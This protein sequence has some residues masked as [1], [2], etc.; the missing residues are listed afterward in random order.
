MPLAASVSTGPATIT[1]NWPNPGNASLLILRRTKGQGGASW[2]QILNV[3]NSNLSMLT[4]NGVAAGQIYEYVIQRNVGGL[5]AFGYAHVAINANPVNS[6]GKILIF[7]DSTTADAAGVELVRMKNDMRGDGWWPIP[8]KT[9]PAATPQSVKAQIVTA[10]NA[11]PLNVKAVLLIGNVPIP[12][13]GNTNWDGH[14]EHAGAWPCDA[15]YG[16]IN[17]NWTDVSINNTSPARDANDNVPGDGKFDQSVI[18]SVVELQVGRIDFRRLDPAAFGASDHV[19][20]LKRYLEKNHRWRTGQ[21]T[22]DNK[23]LV[24]DNFGYFGGEAFAANGF[25]N[26]YPLVGQLNL[27]EGDFFN[28]TDNQSFLMGYGCGGGNYNG[29]GGVGSSTNFMSDSVN[30]V[31]SNLFGSYFGD[32]DFES[33]PFMPSALA[34]RGG[35]LT[36]SWAGRPHHFYQAL[37][38][39]ETVGYVMWETMNA[40]FNNGFYGSYGESGAHVALLGDPTLRAHVVKPATNLTVAPGGCSSVVLNW[41]A[42]AD[43]VSGYHIY[44]ALSQD[45]PYTRLTVN[46]VAG[47]TFT[48]NTPLLDTLF[49]QVRAIKNVSSFG[50]GTYA[51]NAVGPIEFLV[52]TGQGGPTVTATGGA[53][54]CSAFTVTLS[55]DATPASITSWSWSGPNGFSSNVQNPTVSTAGVYTV[56]A[57][58]A[59][60]CAATATATVILD[61]TA[62]EIEATV[63]NSINCANNSAQ[64]TVSTTGLS[65]ISISGPNGF[66]VTGPTATATQTGTYTIT[67]ISDANGCFGS[68]TVDLAGD[69][70]QPEVSATNSGLINCINSTSGLLA[71]ANV[72]GA[73]FSWE[74]PCLDG[75]VATCGGTYTVTAVNTNNGCTG[76]A[77]TVVEENFEVPAGS[78]PNPPM[79]TCATPSVSLISNPI[80]AGTTVVWDGPCLIPGTPPM[81]ECA[82]TYSLVAT[83]PV[84]GCTSVASVNVTAN[85]TPPVV[86]LPPIPAITCATPCISFVVPDIPNIRLYYQG[87]LLPVGFVIEFCQPGVFTL[88]AISLLNGCSSEVLIVVE[89]DVDL[90]VANAGPDQTLTCASSSVQLNGD[91][92][93]SGANFTRTWSGPNGYVSS[94]LNPTVSIAGVYVLTV[95]NTDNGCTTT[96]AVTVIAD[97]D[98]PI[99]NPSV[100]GIINCANPIVVLQSGNNNPAA[101]YLWVGPGFASSLPT[102]TVSVP[103]VYTVQVVIGNCSASGSVEVEQAP[104]LDVSGTPTVI[105]CDGVASACISVSGGTPPYAILWS[106]G[107]TTPCAE[108]NTPAMIGVSVTDNGGCTFTVDPVLV[109]SIPILMFEG[110]TVSNTCN[111]SSE[112]CLSIL[113]GVEPYAIQWSNGDTG[114]CTTLNATGL[115]GA[116]VTDAAGC[117]IVLPGVVVGVT[118]VILLDVIVVNES[119]VNAGD[120]SIDLTTIGGTPPFTYVWNTGATTQDLTGLN[121]GQY[122]V[123]ATDA[124]GCTQVLSAT[125]NTTS[126]VGEADVFAQLQLSPN[127]TEGVAQISLQLHQKAGVQIAVRDVAGRLIWE[128]ARVETDLMTMPLD[129][130]RQPAGIYQVVIQVDNQV[131][132]RQ[133]SVQ[134]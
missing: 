52:F 46:P 129:L 28:D 94:D 116:T 24:D 65:S 60:G 68:T 47:T 79:I 82:G 48:D 2:Q 120:G 96:D 17:G 70:L 64:I 56:T 112:I 55:A 106:N 1:L 50:G 35:I 103:G 75:F 61:A 131:F 85:T 21:Y 130:S 87:Q 23:A 22:V 76:Q 126:S 62:P 117:E 25:R 107:N 91:G 67:A 4:D 10:Y 113:G 124:N 125:V 100:S 95:T 26:A 11:D 101:T 121:G 5:N 59:S 45:G 18:P 29:A 84:S 90:P 43:A 12:Y 57:T 98:L 134:R 83:H 63:S 99:V 20:L 42:S 93:S 128:S 30:I 36:C 78:V 105:G 13:S 119:A 74:G 66:F 115:I 38:S 89:Q 118:P 14:P 44:R 133:L 41:T 86:S 71:T 132:V 92:S 8:F 111:G 102:P 108:F 16:D 123:T 109:E 15:Y 81:A 49:Y 34:S 53:L 6:R 127:P 77:T 58:D 51:N 40:Q 73:T 31:F 9:G 80:P 114:A 69:F 72:P 97:N 32:W 104:E 39:G 110:A 7:I 19:A 37:A 27:V 3:T 54:T 88:E 33:N 122:T